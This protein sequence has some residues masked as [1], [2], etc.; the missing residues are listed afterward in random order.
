MVHRA[1]KTRFHAL[2]PASSAGSGGVM[3]AAKLGGS[4]ARMRSVWSSGWRSPAFPRSLRAHSARSRP[5]GASGS[6]SDA[7]CRKVRKESRSGESAG[8]EEASREHKATPK[9]NSGARTCGVAEQR[10]AAGCCVHSDLVA[11]ARGRRRLN[12]SDGSAQERALQRARAARKHTKRRLSALGRVSACQLSGSTRSSVRLRVAAHSEACWVTRIVRDGVRTAPRVSRR[13]AQHQQAVALHGGAVREAARGGGGGGARQRGQ[14]HAARRK[15]QLVR[16]PHLQRA[17]QRSQRRR[18]SAQRSKSAGNRMH[19]V[20][21]SIQQNFP[22][23]AG[24]CR[25]AG[26]WRAAPP[27]ATPLRWC[28][29]QTSAQSAPEVPQVAQISVRLRFDACRSRCAR[30]LPGQPRGTS[31]R[32]SHGLSSATKEAQ[33][34]STAKRRSSTAGC[35]ATND[36]TASTPV[37]PHPASRRYDRYDSRGATSC[38]ALHMPREGASQRR[39]CVISRAAHAR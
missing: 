18:E 25:D 14:K 3:A 11:P 28:R 20:E 32:V 37:Q 24:P 12:V 22:K 9:Q 6:S 1:K 16:Q 17:H 5:V 38:A 29:P 21:G 35:R 10:V 2:A 7:A 34:W 36:G 31:C 13:V 15:V 26:A 27:P 33:R 4:S 23:V 30:A 8:C 19:K 39:F